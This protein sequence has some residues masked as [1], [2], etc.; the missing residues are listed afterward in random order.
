MQSKARERAAGAT[1]SKPTR[2][3]FVVVGLPLFWSQLA[4]TP[5][6]I[7]LTRR[8]LVPSSLLTNSEGNSS[9]AVD[10]RRAPA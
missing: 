3:R 7:S 9:P 1:D 10:L 8:R 4:V 5:L 2:L 6:P